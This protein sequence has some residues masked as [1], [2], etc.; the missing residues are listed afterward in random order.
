M[1]CLPMLYKAIPEAEG[2]LLMGGLLWQCIHCGS[3]PWLG[4]FTVSHRPAIS[5][6]AHKKNTEKNNCARA[7][8][9]QGKKKNWK[10]MREWNNLVFP[11]KETTV[12]VNRKFELLLKVETSKYYRI[13]EMMKL[14]KKYGEMKKT[15]MDITNQIIFIKYKEEENTKKALI[16]MKMM[17]K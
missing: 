12:C 7:W 5:L 11:Q 4:C 3:G 2:K 16:W 17:K 6:I 8:L 9:P 14:A 1:K 10:Q 13:E 15:K